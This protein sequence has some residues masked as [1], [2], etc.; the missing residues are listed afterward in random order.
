MEFGHIMYDD[1]DMGEWNSFYNFM[2]DCF[3]FYL[4]NG[5]LAAENKNL[6]FKKLLHTTC[7]DWIDWAELNLKPG[8]YAKSEIHGNFVRD[9]PDFIKVKTNTTTTWAKL[10]C[11]YKGWVVTDIVAERVRKIRIMT[12]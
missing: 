12:G 2:F 9:N 11:Q 3:Q 7:Q 4:N 8:D 6:S 1:W 10:Y 5:L